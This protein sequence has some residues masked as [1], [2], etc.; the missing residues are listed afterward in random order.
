MADPQRRWQARVEIA[1]RD[2][3]ILEH[4]T[5]AARGSLLNPMTRKEESEKSLDLMAPVIGVK[6]AQSL[7]GAIWDIEKLKDTRALGRL[8][9]PS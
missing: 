6:R 2:G 9:R 5:H 4:Y 8:C 3:R 7:V 1:L